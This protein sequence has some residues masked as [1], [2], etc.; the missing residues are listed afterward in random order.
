MRVTVK[1]VFA[2]VS[3]LI[4][5]GCSGDAPE[6]KTLTVTAAPDSPPEVVTLLAAS[7]PKVL[8]ACPGLQKYAADMQFAGVENNFSFA[9]P[10]AQRIDIVFKVSDQPRS[11][12]SEYKAMGHSCYYSVNRSGNGLAISKSPCTAICRD[13]QTPPGAPQFEAKL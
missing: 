1:V 3:A 8:K 12:P 10:D 5:A 2:F 9:P 13:A 7:W 6:Q 11:I 4:M